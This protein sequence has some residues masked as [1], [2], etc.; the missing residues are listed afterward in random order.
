M[1]LM[2]Q[3]WGF[4]TNYRLGHLGGHGTQILAFIDVFE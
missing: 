2:S 3:H 1:D 4:V